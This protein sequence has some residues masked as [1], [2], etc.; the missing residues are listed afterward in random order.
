M[1]EVKTAKRRERQREYRTKNRER[2]SEWH[3]EYYIKNKEC[4]LEQQREYRA[5]NKKYIN[6]YK[7]EYRAKNKEHIREQEREY[8]AKNRE[9][10]CEW[11]HEY[12]VKNKERISEYKREYYA[13]KKTESGCS[14]SEIEIELKP[15]PFCGGKLIY[16]RHIAG[17]NRVIC[18]TCGA[19]GGMGEVKDDAAEA[20]NERFLYER[21]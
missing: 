9:R 20:W 12:Y 19:M 14:M 18:R 5:K 15:C 6:E 16:I 1:D 21:E 2:I 7:R 3:R 8:Y 13:Q 11:Q 10:R 17:G 4:I